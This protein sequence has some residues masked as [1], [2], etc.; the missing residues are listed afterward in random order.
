MFHVIE[1]TEDEAGHYGALVR[2]QGEARRVLH[3]TEAHDWP[4]GAELECR[5]VLEAM[6]CG[7]R[8]A[9]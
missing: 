6:Y 1:L 9:A 4:E 7:P 3:R 2:V 5:E 8:V